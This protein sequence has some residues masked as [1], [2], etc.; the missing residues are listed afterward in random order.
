MYP[1]GNQMFGMFKKKHTLTDRAVIEMCAL[2]KLS[3]ALTQTFKVYN[4]SVCVVLLKMFGT[5]AFQ[6]SI[7]LAFDI[8]LIEFTSHKGKLHII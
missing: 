6:M 3:R 4:I 8:F 5:F 1:F 2:E 7:F